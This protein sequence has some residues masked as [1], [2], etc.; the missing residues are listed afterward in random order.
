[1][2]AGADDTVRLWA[3]QRRDD[4]FAAQVDEL[5]RR[6]ER[7]IGKYLVQMVGDPGL[8]EDLLQDVFHDAFRTREQLRQVRNADAWLFGLA[9]NRALN[10]LRRGRRLQAALTRLAR[11]SAPSEPDHELVALR[12][13]LERHVAPEDRSLLIL[14]YLHGFDACELGEMTG[15]SP[16][17][18]RQRLAR[19]RAKLIAAATEED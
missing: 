11:R 12:D 13:L 19:A 14:R 9:R 4:A 10:A 6:C 1:M 8:A 7:R 15:R 2:T 16:G 17:A 3:A 18:V 5:F